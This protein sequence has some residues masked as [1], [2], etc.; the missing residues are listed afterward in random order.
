M[1]EPLSA[2]KS[3]TENHRLLGAVRIENDE[4]LFIYDEIGCFLDKHG[5]P[6]RNAG[7]VRWETPAGA[8][9]I[10][11]QHLLLFSASGAFVEIRLA[12]QGRLVQV[13]EG[14]DLRIV[15]SRGTDQDPLLMVLRG[16]H[17]DSRGLSER[18]SEI[19][20]TASLGAAHPPPNAWDEWD[21]A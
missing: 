13:L 15:S 11:G 7:Y 2:L 19:V 9:A 10:R 18:I 12:A 17:E 1:V 5:Q 4:M 20:P 8:Y 3:R 14:R 21:M 16:A 6:S